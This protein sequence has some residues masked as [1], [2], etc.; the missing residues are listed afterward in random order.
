MYIPNAELQALPDKF[1]TVQRWVRGKAVPSRKNY[2]RY[3]IAFNRLTGKDPDQ[4]L[5][6]AK[7]VDS[8]EVQ[9]LIDRVS[10][11]LEDSKN[12]GHDPSASKYNFKIEMRSFLGTNGYNSLPKSNLSY[13]LQQWHRGYTREEVRKLLGYLDEPLPKLYVTIAAESGLRARTVLG[14]KYDYIREDYEKDLVPVAIRLSPDYYKGKKS[15]G[16]TFL[17]TRSISLLKECI[18]SGLVR[19]DSGARLVPRSYSNIFKVVDRARVK[20]SIDK[21]VQLNHGLRKDFEHALDESGVDHEVKMVIGGNFERTRARHYTGRE[22]D[23]LRPIYAKAYP[24]IDLEAT[25][26]ELETKLGDWQ[27]EKTAL[28]KKV[29]DLEDERSEMREVVKFTKELMSHPEIRKIL[30]KKPA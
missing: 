25:N 29:R 9:D 7:T 13:T 30:G 19:T 5:A 12:P 15:A 14:L 27:L 22:W 10:D 8:L 6:W 26:P 17:G 24:H 1:L 28:E 18:K 23:S 11:S 21:Q 20:A 2:C 3:M 4:F 16:F